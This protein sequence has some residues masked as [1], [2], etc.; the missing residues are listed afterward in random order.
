MKG[1]RI[2]FEDNVIAVRDDAKLYKDTIA[3]FELDASATMPATP[4]N[5]VVATYDQAA[6]IIMVSNGEAQRAITSVPWQNR[7]DWAI[8]AIDSL[9]ANQAARDPSPITPPTG[10]MLARLLAAEDAIVNLKATQTILNAAI[11]DLNNRVT[12]LENAP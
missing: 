12:A 8:G 1:V 7:F 11:I 3:N 6:G 9:L 2:N 5:V 10:T 4:P